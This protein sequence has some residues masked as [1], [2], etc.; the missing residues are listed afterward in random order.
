MT[1]S[2]VRG[3]LLL[4][5]TAFFCMRSLDPFLNMEGIYPAYRIGMEKNSDMVGKI[6]PGKW[7]M[8]GKIPIWSEKFRHG[9]R[10]GGVHEG[11]L[12]KLCELK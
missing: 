1:P 8:V 6:P 7:D 11:K 3:L 4:P 9:K 12:T 10:Q 5:P 2:A